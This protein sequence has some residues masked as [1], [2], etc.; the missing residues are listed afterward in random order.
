V[1]RDAEKVEQLA[2]RF[3]RRAAGTTDLDKGR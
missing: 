2:K 3:K 1:G